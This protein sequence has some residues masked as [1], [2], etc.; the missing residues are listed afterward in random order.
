MAVGFGHEPRIASLGVVRS[1][2]GYKHLRVLWNGHVEF[3]TEVD[4]FF[5]RFSEVPGSRDV[6]KKF[7]YPYAISEPVE[8]FILFVREVCRLATFEGELEFRLGFHR[9]RGFYLAPGH[10]QSRAYMSTPFSR[11][12]CR[13]WSCWMATEFSCR[14]WA[15]CR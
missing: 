5:F 11:A 3:W 13:T 2:I 8:N 7:L 9:I 14:S 1:D 6:E 4:D 10:P 12:H 15:E